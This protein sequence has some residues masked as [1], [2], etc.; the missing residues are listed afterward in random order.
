M[1][2]LHS[3]IIAMDIQEYIF[4]GV[5]EQYCLGLLNEQERAFVIEMSLLYPEVKRELNNIEMAFEYF[6]Q[7]D[8][9]Y[10]KPDLDSKPASVFKKSILNIQNLPEISAAS[11]AASW[12]KCVEHLIPGLIN[13]DFICHVLRE[14]DR[15][16]QMLIIS[17]IDIPD[18]THQQILESFLILKGSCRCT[19]GNTDVELAESDFI[20]IPLNVQHSVHLL[21]PYV[22][23]VLQHKTIA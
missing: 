13:D 7:N 12:L 3:L 20:E 5:L 17:R 8:V 22:V 2:M 11:D 1:G 15:I 19:I 9:T 21:S 14:D 16:S 23:A 18:E 10:P 6:S 4:S